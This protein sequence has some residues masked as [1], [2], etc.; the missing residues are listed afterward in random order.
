MF[1]PGTVIIVLAHRKK[2]FMIH[3]RP[4]SSKHSFTECITEAIDYVKE[5]MGDDAKKCT[6]NNLSGAIEDL[7]KKYGRRPSSDNKA[8]ELNNEHNIRIIGLLFAAIP[9]DRRVEMTEKFEK[10]IAAGVCPVF[11]GLIGKGNAEG[12][13]SMVWPLALALAPYA[14]TVI[15][16]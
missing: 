6:P 14:D 12:S 15:K 4:A 10:I 13:L 1:P 2:A 11:I 8:P 7:I 5:C 3:I 9:E 16:E